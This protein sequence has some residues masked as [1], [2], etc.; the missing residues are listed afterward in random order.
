MSAGKGRPV[1]LAQHRNG[2]GIVGGA[3]RAAAARPRG[4][5]IADVGLDIAG[6]QLGEGRALK[7]PEA[8]P[9]APSA[10][11]SVR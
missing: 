4:D 7:R 10:S 9:A 1:V 11:A 8:L 3:E 5:D 2:G 6:E